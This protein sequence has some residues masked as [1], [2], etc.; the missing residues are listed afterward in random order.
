[1]RLLMS[2]RGVPRVFRPE[3]L[4]RGV[5]PIGAICGDRGKVGLGRYHD[6]ETS[7]G[8]VER[9]RSLCAGGIN[10]GTRIS[11]H[12]HRRLEPVQGCRRRPS[13]TFPFASYAPPLHGQ[14]MSRCTG[15]HPLVG[16][17]ARARS[18]RPEARTAR[19]CGN[20]AHWKR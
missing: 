9:P 18:D 4:R 20:A 2:E 13:T 12:A 16:A 5:A 14:R 10:A 3:N 1:M 6:A 15:F 7:T 19:T 8:L 11:S 17:A